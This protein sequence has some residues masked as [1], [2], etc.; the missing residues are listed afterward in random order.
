SIQYINPYAVEL[1][2][3]ANESAILGKDWF[4]HFAYPLIS[5]NFRAK[6]QDS[7]M[8]RETPQDEKYEIVNCRGE[9]KEI[10]WTNVLV[11]DDEGNLDGTVSIGTDTTEQARFITRIQ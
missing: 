4:E 1:L 5:E 3:Y 7:I 10:S 6:F 9:R 8:N 11:Y 2:G